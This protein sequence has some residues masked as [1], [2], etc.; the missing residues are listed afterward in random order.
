MNL[1]IMVM[2]LWPALAQAQLPGGFFNQKAS[3]RKLLVQ[4]IAA[5][6]VYKRY[7]KTGYNIVSS[8]IHT[9]RDIK[10]GDF[11]LHSAFFTS[12]K[13]VSPQIKRYAKVAEIISLHVQLVRNCGAHLKA[14]RQSGSL[15]EEEL[16]YIAR[17]FSRLLDAAA[18][19]LDE[20][21]VLTTDGQLEMND[22]GRMQRIDVLYTEALQQYTF[23]KSFHNE[24]V[25]LALARNAAYTDIEKLRTMQGI[26]E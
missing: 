7:V 4:Q 19:L 14:I 25:Q 1:V 24:S 15:T 21:I 17:V 16:L 2:T 26:E 13:R 5:L 11:G 10:N 8:G 20:L 18:A 12:L 6:E 9:V 22:D 23:M 3:E